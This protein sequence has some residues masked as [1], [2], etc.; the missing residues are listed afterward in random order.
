MPLSAD[1]VEKFEDGSK[2]RCRRSY[3]EK[4]LLLR[5]SGAAAVVVLCRRRE[6][7]IPQVDALDNACGSPSEFLNTIRQNWNC[8]ALLA[9]ERGDPRAMDRKIGPSAAQR[10]ASATRNSIAATA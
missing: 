9:R 1:C 5:C 3:L 10:S 6:M 7:N 8:H 2:Q 4:F